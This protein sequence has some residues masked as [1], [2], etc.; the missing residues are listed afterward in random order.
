MSYGT[1]RLTLVTTYRKRWSSL[2]Q[3]STTIPIIFLPFDDLRG[4]QH[5]QE[6]PGP[7]MGVEVGRA[8]LPG[9]AEPVVGEIHGDVAGRVA[10]GPGD[11]RQVDLE[12]G[13]AHA[14][15]DP[16][17]RERRGGRRRPAGT[18]RRQRDAAGSGSRDDGA[19]GLAAG[20]ACVTGS[21]A[22]VVVSDRTPAARKVTPSAVRSAGT[23]RVRI[24]SARGPMGR[25]MVAAVPVR[26]RRTARTGTL[27]AT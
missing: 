2:V 16:V 19:S 25:G 26:R 20:P 6:H 18:E 12:R 14:R 11:D 8:A 3:T 22:A 7:G 13:D 15:R 5:R 17:G 21:A 1:W 10:G 27:R 4:G 9:L 23:I 24:R